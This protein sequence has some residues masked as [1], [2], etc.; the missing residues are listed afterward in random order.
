MTMKRIS[1]FTLLFIHILSAHA[2]TL[3]EGR[4]D[5]S[6]IY[7]GTVHDYIV[8]LP[9]GYDPATPACL[10]VG[11][12]GILC[13]A[14]AVIDSL[15]RAGV[16]PLT[17]GVYLQSGRIDG[18]DG[19]VL[20][21]NR[22]N[23]FDATDSRFARFLATEV[24]P[25]V[26]RH[27]NILPG[28][29]HHAI[30]GLSSGGIAAFN[31]AWHRPDL[32][33]RVFCGCGTFVP[34][35]GGNAIEAVV[36]KH[37]PL[38]LRVFLQDGS[39][40]SWNPLFGSW[41]EANRKLDTALEFAGYDHAADWDDSGH[42]VR[43]ST[44]IFADVMTWL[45]RDY[46]APVK[47]GI[48][49]NDLLAPLLDGAGEWTAVDTRPA[50]VPADEVV[51]LVWPDSSL[52]I[53]S[54]PGTGWLSQSIAGPEGERTHTQRF[55]W[56]HSYDNNPPRVIDLDLDADGNLWVLTG[57]CIQICDQ[58]GRVRGIL[59]LPVGV[60]PSALA[61]AH[62]SATLSTPM[63]TY[64]RRLNVAPAAPASTPPSQGQG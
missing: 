24:L 4:I 6:A 62:G 43:R 22:S 31:A 57:E 13:H 47:P 21:Y 14:P 64:T 52:I 28:A 49:G 16:M 5:S 51:T 27:A 2:Y 15:T 54:A 39:R 45:W 53:D 18:A 9:E 44:E 37:E 19:R 38:P 35:R 33:S 7:P 40:D 56:L 26:A 55:Y 63:G 50:P 60:Q 1:L 3:I 30:F 58:N 20:R 41:Y 29:E 11:L 59:A 42:S 34:M 25:V 10:Y 61:L 8:S 32:F 46:P 17:V 12:D 48:T 23:E 36:R